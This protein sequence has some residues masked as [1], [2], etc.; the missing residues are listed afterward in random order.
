MDREFEWEDIGDIEKGRPTLGPWTNVTAYRL[1]YMSLR[2]VLNSQLGREKSKEIFVAAGRLAGE[3]IFLN[4]VGEVADITGLMIKVASLFDDLKVGILKVEK[5]DE[6]KTE[7]T[8]TVSE[9]LDCS[10]V[11]V[12]GETKCAWDE[13]LIAGI[14]SSFL[15]VATTAKEIDCWA[16]GAGICRFEIKTG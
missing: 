16:T 5:A 14:L 10:G 9:D 1:L 7:F 6:K 11:P 8:L 2:Q 3:Q 13:G 12:D 15:K 4:L